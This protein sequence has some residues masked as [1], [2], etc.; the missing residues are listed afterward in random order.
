[1]ERG[2]KSPHDH[3]SKG[4]WVHFVFDIKH[5]L[6]QKSRLITG[7]PSEQDSMNTLPIHSWTWDSI[8]AKLNQ[9]FGWRS[10]ALITSALAFMWMIWPVLWSNLTSSFSNSDVGDASSREL[11]RSPII[12]VDISSGILVTHCWHGEPKH[13]SNTSSTNVKPAWRATK[14]MNISNW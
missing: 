1:M 12:F 7:Q 11:E 14:R 6:H 10:V 2:M 9:I 4:I 13:T 8:H 5:D 3:A